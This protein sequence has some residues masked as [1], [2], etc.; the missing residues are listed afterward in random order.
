ML[1]GL[2]LAQLERVIDVNF[3]GTVFMIKAFLPGLL[4]R[5]QA[6]ILN[7]ASMAACVPVPGQVAYSASKAAVK[8]LSEGLHSE[9]HGTSVGVTLACPGAVA[10]DL[11][12]NSGVSLPGAGA[13]GSRIRTMTANTAARIMIDAIEAGKPRVMVGTDAVCMD[14]LSR[15]SPRLAAGVIRRVMRS[16]L[17]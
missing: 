13:A 3:L 9:L 14:I 6:H 16:I 10:T 12:V 15:L 2:D 8:A 1:A 7:V 17:R 5:P 4:T 11:A